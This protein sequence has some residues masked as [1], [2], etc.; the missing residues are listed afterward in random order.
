MVAR[1]FCIN[2][3]RHCL[4]VTYR[5]SVNAACALATYEDSS[6]PGTPRPPVTILQVVG[7]RR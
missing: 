2:V 1:N 3:G 5:V 6:W 4:E 7:S